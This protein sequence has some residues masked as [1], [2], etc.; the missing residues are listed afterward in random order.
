MASRAV[1][2]PERLRVSATARE[3]PT[4]LIFTYFHYRSRTHNRYFASQVSSFLANADVLQKFNW[5]ELRPG[6]DH[7]TRGRCCSALFM[8]MGICTYHG[9]VI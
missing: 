8:G 4:A 6:S 7:G 1:D 2:V 3:N 5:C 9:K